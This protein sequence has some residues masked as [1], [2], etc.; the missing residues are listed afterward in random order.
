MT[1]TTIHRLKDQDIAAFDLG[2]GSKI[3]FAQ[4]IKHPNMTAGFIRLGR[5]EEIR[6]WPYWYEEVVYVT[7]GTGRITVWP[8]PFVSSETHE[9]KAGDLFYIG[10]ATKV[11]FHGSDDSFEMLYVTTPD[12]GIG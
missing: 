12:S 6:D 2:G 1:N 5:G 9:L 10:K 4:Y 11:T 7:R 8:V 3:K